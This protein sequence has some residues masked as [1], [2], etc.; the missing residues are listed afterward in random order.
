MHHRAVEADDCPR[1]SMRGG[2]GVDHLRGAQA[3]PCRSTGCLAM[4]SASAIREPNHQ[5]GPRICR[6]EYCA[7]C[8]PYS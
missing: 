8:S 3:Q 5:A 4:L 2:R 7:T 1:G 6:T